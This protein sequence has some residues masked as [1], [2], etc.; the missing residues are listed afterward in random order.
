MRS[1]GVWWC[2]FHDASM[3]STYIDDSSRAQESNLKIRLPT[4]RNIDLATNSNPKDRI[5]LI[6][7]V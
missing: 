1:P 7:M 6:Y 2:S 3:R 4:G 5:N